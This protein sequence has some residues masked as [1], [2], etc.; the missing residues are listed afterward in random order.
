MI[1]NDNYRRKGSK[2]RHY[3]LYLRL[4][5]LKSSSYFQKKEHSRIIFFCVKITTKNN[6]VYYSA[7]IQLFDQSKSSCKRFPRH[8]TPILT[9]NCFLLLCW[10][11]EKKRSFEKI[12]NLRA[13][14][15]SILKLW[16]KNKLL[17]TNAPNV[18]VSGKFWPL[19]KTVW[20]IILCTK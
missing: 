12:T 9:I 17:R 8:T 10:Q 19:C 5:V 2:T 15:N 1:F 7:L 11:Q 3:N 20:N 18:L 6:K 14:W 13:L 16:K 4:L